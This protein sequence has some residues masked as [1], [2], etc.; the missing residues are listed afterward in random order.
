M[1]PDLSP[2]SAEVVAAKLEQIA[3]FEQPILAEEIAEQP[4]LAELLW[5]LQFV[6]QPEN[7]AGG[8]KKFCA[9]FIEDAQ[10]EV[11]T[12]KMVEWGEVRSFSFEQLCVLRGEFSDSAWHALRTTFAVL[13]ESDEELLSLDLPKDDGLGLSEYL[14]LPNCERRRNLDDLGKREQSRLT[15]LCTPEK[16]RLACADEAR[17][18]LAEYLKRLCEE[19][20][21]GFRRRG[22]R[23]WTNTGHR[24]PWYFV[25]VA[26]S[27]LSFIDR[28]KKQLAT[29]IARTE[30]T[31][32]VFEW[33]DVAY[34]TQR[35][36][37]IE[38]NSRFGK[39]EAIQLWCDMNPGIA[40]LVNTP[41]TNA[42]G[43][44]LREVAKALGIDS[45]P[46]R[47]GHDLR[48]RIDYVLRFS[49][50]LLCFDES[51][52]LLPGSYSR[53][54]TPARLN[55]VRRSLMDRKMP[56][57][58]VYTPQTNQPAKKR[59]VKATGYTMEQ[60]DER[61]LMTVNLPAEL[62]ESDLIAV[63]RIHFPRLAEL[64]LKYVV[65]KALATERNYVSDIEK[66]ATLAN[67]KAKQ[68]GRAV[69]ILDDINSAIGNVLPA[70]PRVPTEAPGAL[71]GSPARGVR[72]PA[73]SN[74][75]RHSP[76]LE[77]L[78][79]N[80]RGGVAAFAGEPAK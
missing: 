10:Q 6:S 21:V 18:H 46:G 11:A 5:F 17:S 38:G 24:A 44:L 59:F 1:S 35:S 66:I 60:F 41:A 73:P 70:P 8:L 58:F 50:L 26:D 27:L 75:H 31:K 69:P 9:D 29:R 47:R 64:H 14:G 79:R 54:T 49:K 57:V 37:L 32:L 33:M 40:R 7:Y 39:T 74:S 55:W 4:R 65:S 71:V 63:A 67:F 25:N 72:K 16:V 19:P 28:R 56:A 78:S 76:A 23:N 51:N 2:I 3:N 53:N 30:I 77:P 45:A 22:S 62:C 43:D 52:F 13:S 48:E 61:I 80:V 36:V 68:G 12:A 34:G 42:M 15:A 20:A